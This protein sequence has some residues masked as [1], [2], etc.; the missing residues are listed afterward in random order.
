MVIYVASSSVVGLRERTDGPLL[1]G[2]SG[3]LGKLPR[4]TIMLHIELAD[5]LSFFKTWWWALMILDLAIAV[6]CTLFIGRVLRGTQS[7]V[8]NTFRITGAPWYLSALAVYHGYR[9]VTW[10]KRLNAARVARENQELFTMLY[11]ISD[12][13]EDVWFMN[14]QFVDH[15]LSE[16]AAAMSEASLTQE[17]ARRN[18]RL[19]DIK[20]ADKNAK[21]QKA[22]FWAHHASAK[23]NGFQVKETFGAYLR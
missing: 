16:M 20:L 10:P 11:G 17:K 4:R 14:Q 21:M 3:Y 6:L 19:E 22:V 15:R 13:D 9:L 2:S 8:T 18:G 12:L 23:A 7:E 5:W 1:S